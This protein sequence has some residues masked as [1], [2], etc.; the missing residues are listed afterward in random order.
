MKNTSINPPIP[1]KLFQGAVFCACGSNLTFANNLPDYIEREADMCKTISVHHYSGSACNG[2]IPSLSQLLEDEAS[3]GAVE[4]QADWIKLTHE[5]G[6]IYRQGEANSI[7]CGGYS[8]VSNVF[9]AALWA[10]D[11]MF[12][13]ANV[14]ADGVNFHNSGQAY[15]NAISYNSSSSDVPSV[16]P[17]YYAIYAMAK[18]I[19]TGAK[20]VPYNITQS[21]N[22]MIKIWSVVNDDNQTIHVVVIHKDMNATQPATITLSLA[23]DYQS[24]AQ[25]TRLTAPSVTSEY[26]LNF[27]GQTFDGSQ[28]GYPV[29]EETYTTVT[30]N[31][32]RQF[33]FTLD[34]LSVAFLE[35]I[36]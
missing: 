22:E 36:P 19:G 20:L 16:H 25:L 15:Y 28:D 7:S 29:G 21:T 23:N 27:A 17:L 5:A 14:S 26:G 2:H 30:M 11:Y 31:S 1:A 12:N 34:P 3:V 10:L 4:F 6:L 18:T 33:V 8:G 35:I 24:T 9:G 32:N 13:L